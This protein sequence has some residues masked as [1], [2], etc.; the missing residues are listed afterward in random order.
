MAGFNASKFGLG[1]GKIGVCSGE[2]LAEPF[3]WPLDALNF[4]PQ[5]LQRAKMLGEGLAL[6]AEMRCRAISGNEGECGGCGGHV[7]VCLPNG[8]RKCVRACNFVAQV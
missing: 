4:R 5:F 7:L 8:A 2:L 1:S 6:G 3:D